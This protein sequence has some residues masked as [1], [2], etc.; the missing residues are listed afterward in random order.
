MTHSV[1]WKPARVATK[2]NALGIAACFGAMGCSP[3]PQPTTPA[4]TATVSQPAPTT[5][6]VLTPTSSG[7]ASIEQSSGT[8]APDA[9]AAESRKA[10]SPISLVPDRVS[11]HF[12]IQS[13]GNNVNV[14]R[15]NNGE[16]NLQLMT[17]P[18]RGA[19]ES[20]AGYCWALS[21]VD[22]RAYQNLRVRFS[23]VVRA[24]ELQFKLETKDN[25]FQDRSLRMP[26]VGDVQIP[27][28]NFPTVQSAI[29]R[30]C[31]V[32]ASPSG[33]TRNVDAD[34]TMAQVSLE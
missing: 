29:G 22:G 21:E 23:R 11:D 1:N 24:Q 9:S 15:T 28:S 30:F 7:T 25:R 10:T 20:W 2:S 17:V 19:E 16:W 34:V 8:E 26:A 32:L 3:T 12:P 33:V 31:L 5:N 14:S 27:I 4:P 18:R 6:A 13:S